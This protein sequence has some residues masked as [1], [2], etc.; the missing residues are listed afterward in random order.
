MTQQQQPRGLTMDDGTSI[1]DKLNLQFNLQ[2]H[3]DRMSLIIVHPELDENRYNWAIEHLLDLLEEYGD[4]EF[5]TQID[6]IEAKY[7]G[8][9]E[10]AESTQAETNLIK[11][12]NRQVFKAL[13]GLIKRLRLGLEMQTIEKIGF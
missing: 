7:K 2:R 13:N 8:L 11:Q 5:H 1:R 3:L 6:S 10:K 9:I 4:E 12:K